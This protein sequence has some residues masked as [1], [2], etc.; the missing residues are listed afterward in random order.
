VTPHNELDAAHEFRV[1]HEFMRRDAPVSVLYTVCVCEA[2]LFEN[3]Y[4]IIYIYIYILP[5]AYSGW[6]R[7]R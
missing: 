2:L 1:P 4:Q 6:R 5:G 3:L 7:A